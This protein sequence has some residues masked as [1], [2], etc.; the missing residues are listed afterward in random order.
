MSGVVADCQLKAGERDWACSSDA[1]C[2]HCHIKYCKG[3]TPVP[4][5]IDTPG[6]A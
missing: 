4:L 2:N 1:C 6:S 5:D 3:V